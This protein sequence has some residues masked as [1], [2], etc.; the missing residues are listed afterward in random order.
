[1]G[2]YQRA[3]Q[4]LVDVYRG[5]DLFRVV[6]YDAGAC[7]EANA[8]F[9]RRVGVHYVMVLNAQQPTLYGEAQRI[10][11][12][13]PQSPLAVVTVARNASRTTNAKKPK[14]RYTVHATEEMAG[15]LDWTHLR[16]VFRVQRDVLDRDGNVTQS[17]VRYFI[18]S[19]TLSAL[20]PDSWVQLFRDRWAVENDTHHTLDTIF[21]EDGRTWVTADPVG[22]LN[23]I[24]L[25]RLALNLLTLFRSHTLRSESA[26][27][28]PWRDLVRKTYNAVISATDEILDGLRPRKPPPLLI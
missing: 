16:T 17:G 9:T 24:L 15:F 12:R 5:I 19:L 2:A 10:L 13:A 4:E 26:R 14:V 3:L 25:R 27:L 7:S 23:I 8:R 22:A 1:M 11:D 28:T 18:T 20:T 6:M 21:E